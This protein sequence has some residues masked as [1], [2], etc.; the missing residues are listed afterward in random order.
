M[1]RRISTLKYFGIAECNMITVKAADDLATALSHN[2]K[3]LEQLFLN[4]ELPMTHLRMI[5]EVLAKFINLKVFEIDNITDQVIDYLTSIIS[6]NAPLQYFGITNSNLCTTS[7]IKIIKVLQ[8]TSNLQELIINTGATNVIATVVSDNSIVQNLDLHDINL[9][10]VCIFKTLSITNLQVRNKISST[11]ATENIAPTIS[12]DL[13]LYSEKSFPKALQSSFIFKK[14]FINNNITEEAADDIAAAFSSHTQL[15]V[16]DICGNYVKT[17]SM[18]KIAKALQQTSTLQQLYINN[19]IT[20]E[21]V[22]DIAAVI[23]SNTQLKE[24]SFSKN[25]LQSTGAIKIAKA[26]QYVS[27]LTKLNISNNYI[28]DEAADDIAAAICNNIELQELNISENN[29][30]STSAIKIAKALQNISKL[31]INDNHITDKAADDIATAL[32]CNADQ[33]QELDISNN[34]FQAKGVMV[35]AKALQNIV[36][37]KKLYITQGKLG[38]LT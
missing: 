29:L 33:L 16:F 5:M 22:E 12:C 23:Y 25:N 6:Q 35:I 30:Q 21:I 9:Q 13:Q 38:V 19:N 27:T 4:S 2:Y 28:T 36:T 17:P 8:N 20:D 10:T 32:S 11:E 31:Y 7:V 1:L 24:F 3:G 26:L 34:W 14:L 18:I 37:L 15:E